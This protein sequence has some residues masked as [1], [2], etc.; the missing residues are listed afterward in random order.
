MKGVGSGFI[1]APLYK[2]FLASN[3][4]NGP[5]VVGI[6][7]SLPICRVLGN[8]L[9]GTQVCVTPIVSEKPCE[10]PETRSLEREYPEVF[11]ECVVTCAQTLAAKKRGCNEQDELF[12]DPAETFYAKLAEVS[13]VHSFLVK[14]LCRSK[15]K[16][17]L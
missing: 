12:G 1:S 9:A 2:V 15:E 10:V 3:I 13:P 4:V 17:L 11:T 14:P 6:V 8:D 16:I 7:S 5:V